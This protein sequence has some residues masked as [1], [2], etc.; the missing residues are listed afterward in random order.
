MRI[1]FLW[2]GITQHKGKRFEDGLY[3][4]LKRLEK[5]H[6][7]GYFEPLDR[8]RIDLFKP[9]VL[10]FWGAL[11]ENCVKE[12]IQYPYKK[13]ICF[14]GGPIDE[15]NVHGWDLY[16]TESTI[17]EAEL[18][19]LGKPYMRAFGINERLFTPILTE[20]KYDAI[21]WGAFAKWKRHDLFAMSSLEGGLAIG[22]HQDHEPECY[23]ICHQMGVKVMEEQ[24]RDKII[25][26]IRQ[27]Y[28][29]L[30]TSDFWGGGQR[31]TLEAMACGIPPIVMSDSPK[32]CEYVEES[33]YGIICNPDINEIKEAIEK[34]KTIKG[35][36]GHNYVQSKW[37]S[38]HYADNLIKGL[39]QIV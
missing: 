32:N 23:E 12:V 37:T 5:D 27:S 4:A 10:L 30:N 33:G 16:F 39:K 15:S 34:A 17:N 7:I 28:C 6:E 13:A 29:A 8:Y 31:M 11:C 35:F 14:A 18:R 3:L 25:D 38:K 20:K 2:D 21:F 9:D 26:L 24:T 19:V 1:A 36:K 22:Q